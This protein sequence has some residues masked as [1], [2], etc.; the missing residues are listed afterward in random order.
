MTQAATSPEVGRSDGFHRTRIGPSVHLTASTRANAV[1]ASNAIA[2]HPPEQR[3]PANRRD[4]QH[5]DRAEDQADP[6]QCREG[7]PDAQRDTRQIAPRAR[8]A[9]EGH[10]QEVDTD[11]A[12]RDQHDGDREERCAEAFRKVDPREDEQAE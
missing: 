10:S 11:S 5:R 3:T 12:E 7:N 8:L 6:S 2:V 4:G 1:T 9:P